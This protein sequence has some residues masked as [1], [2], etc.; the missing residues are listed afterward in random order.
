MKRRSA[1]ETLPKASGKLTSA[2]NPSMR[3]VW[4]VLVLALSGVFVWA[5]DSYQVGTVTEI[6]GVRLE[7]ESPGPPMFCTIRI[8]S[9]G[10]TFR[11]GIDRRQTKRCETEW[12]VHDQVQFRIVGQDI[13]IKRSKGK[14][15]KGRLL[16]P[17]KTENRN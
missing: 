10:S 8:E 11:F 14:D 15:L 13:F 12:A 5:Q 7:P 2:Y 4:F 9:R 3:A 6:S 16:P 1:T 17:L